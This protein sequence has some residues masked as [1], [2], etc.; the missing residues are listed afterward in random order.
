MDL[1]ALGRAARAAAGV[2]SSAPTAQKDAFLIAAARH[3]RAGSDALGRANEADLSGAKERG[4]QGAMLDRLRLTDGRIEGMAT[5]LEAVARLPDPIGATEATSRRPNGLRVTRQRIP[6]G[7][8]GIIYEA[9]PNVTSEAASLCVKAGNACLLKGGS[10][11]HRSNLAIGSILSAALDE[12]GLPA[13]SVQV[14][15][16]TDRAVVTELIT[17]TESVDLVI[18]RG[19]EGLIRFVTDNA[20]VPVIQHFKG[21]CSV[22]VHGEADPDKAWDIIVNAK[23][24]RPGVCNAAETLLVDAALAGS[25]LPEAARR[26]QEAGVELRG[27]ARTL[28]LVP[29]ATP[30]TDEDWPAE[31][32][33]LILAVRVV[34]D[35]EEAIAHIR[36]YGSDHTECIVTESIAAAQAFV[37]RVHSSCITVNA[38]TRFND[39]FELGLGAEIGISTTRMHAFGPMGLEELTARKFVVHGDGQIRS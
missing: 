31:Y 32:L 4:V 28:E 27:C 26:L 13:A 33:D 39:G 36:R 19:G 14:I 11:A 35:I 1:T 30:A 29:G 5:S 15:E 23:T 7:V 10:E 12:A 9:R 22:Y 21:T 18:P 17:M 2:L 16:S 25:F 34:S 3:L 6:L 24:Q 37:D 8:I 20:R 38:S